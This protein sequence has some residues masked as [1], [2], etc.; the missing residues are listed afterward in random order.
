[1]KQSVNT[2]Y[3]RSILVALIIA[4]ISGLASHSLAVDWNTTPIIQ[5]KDYQAVNA[6]GASTYP[7]NV[8]PVRMVGVVLN[9]NED[10]LDPTSRYC[11]EAGHMWDMGGQAEFYIQAVNLDG[12]PW[13]P[14]PSAAFNDFGGTSNWIGQNYGNHIWHYDDEDYA[15]NSRPWNY[16]QTAWYSELDR[17]HLDRPDTPFSDAQLIRAGDLVEIRARAGLAYQGKMNVNE[18][19]SNSPNCDFDVVL[20]DKNFGLP[21]PHKRSLSEL[22]NSLGTFDFD[23]TRSS[24]AEH[25]QSTLVTIQDVRLTNPAQWGTNRDLTLSDGTGR[26]MTVH[27][28]FDDSFLTVPAPTGYFNVTGIFDQESGSGKDGYQ[29]LVMDAN[30]F[31]V[32]PEPAS[33]VVLASGFLVMIAYSRRK[34]R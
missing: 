6:N 33:M 5:H 31:A 13:D 2:Q 23:P 21:T 4:M 7:A 11:S 18:S 26:S 15:I 34:R 19:H 32:V 24:G 12:T 17:L 28:G 16:T 25:D 8:F 22:E 14:N 27:L 30:G 10:W 20:L 3:I 29:L 1:M 9:N